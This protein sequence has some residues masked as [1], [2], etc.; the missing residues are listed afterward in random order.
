MKTLKFDTAMILKHVAHARAS[1]E[2]SPVYGSAPKAGLLL[3]KDD[4][5]YLMSSGL[6]GM[7]GVVYADGFDPASPDSYERAREAVGGDDFVE[8]LPLE[9]FERA[10]DDGCPQISVRVSDGRVELVRSARRDP[11]LAAFKRG[12]L[13][14]LNAAGIAKNQGR[15]LTGTVLTVN[16]KTITMVSVRGGHVR[17]SPSFLEHVS[18][19]EKAESTSAG[20]AA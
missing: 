9:W 15:E 11:L 10:A 4:G 14:K 19:G 2:H 20:A 8:L 7:P 17:V 3:V 12:E 16:A 13:V 5:I 1:A 18:I 6:P